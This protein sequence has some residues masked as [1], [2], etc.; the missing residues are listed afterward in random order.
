M[1]VRLN[2]R[3]ACV[4]F[5]ALLGALPVAAMAAEDACHSLTPAMAGGPMLPKSR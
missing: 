5:A 1:V 4:A 2:C 3:I